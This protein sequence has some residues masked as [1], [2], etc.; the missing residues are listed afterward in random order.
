[1]EIVP[2]I[3]TLYRSL[4]NRSRY[5]PLPNVSMCRNLGTAREN[6]PEAGDFRRLIRAQPRIADSRSR[7]TPGLPIS[8]AGT[9][10]APSIP[11]WR[12]PPALQLPSKSAVRFL[13]T[14]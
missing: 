13:S 1:L 3:E 8:E 4:R 10:N 5:S 7:F 2:N 6:P 11:V 12:S 9:A 14:R